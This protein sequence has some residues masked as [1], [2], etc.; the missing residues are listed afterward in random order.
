[1]MGLY[2]F[3]VSAKGEDRPISW[4]EIPTNQTVDET[5]NSTV[6][7]RLFQTPLHF[8]AN[9]GQLPEEA[10]YYAKSEGATVHCTD[11]GLVFGFAEGSISVKFSECET[12]SAKTLFSPKSEARRVKPEARGQLEGKVNYFI[13]NDPTSWRTDIPTF[14]EI[15]YPQ[16]YPGIDLIYSGDQRRLKYTFYL[17]PHSHPN[18]IQMIYEDIEGLWIDEATGE[19]V[20]QT[21]WGEM[22]DAKPVAYQE[23]EG[24]RNEVDIS[25][26]LMSEKIVGFALGDYNPNFMLILDPGYSTYLGGDSTDGASDITIDSSGN[27]YVV[28]WTG[29]SD[30]PTQ[31]PHQGSNARAGFDDVFVT[32]LSSSGNTLIYSTYLGG[33]YGE[34]GRGITVDNDGNVYVTG[35][36]SSFDFPTQNP[37]QSSKDGSADAFVTKLSSG[38][39]TL[40]YSTYLGGIHGDAGR[41]ITVD[42][43][44]SAYVTGNTSSSDFPTENPYQG[45][46]GGGNSDAFVTKLNSS[47]NTLTYSTYLGGSGDDIGNDIAVDS[48]ANAYVTGNTSS[49]DFPTQNPYQSSKDGSGDAFVT[50]LSSGGSTLIY[51]TYLGGSKYEQSFAI[52]VDG[53]GNAYVTGQ[54]NSSNFP[55]QNPYQDSLGSVYPDVFIT[56]LNSNGDTLIYSTYLGGSDNDEGSGIVVDNSR[57]AYVTGLT[58]SSNFP[59]QNPYQSSKAGYKDA[60]VTKLSNSGNTLIYST[61]LGGGSNDRGN[62]IAVDREDGVYVTGETNSPNFPT[63]NPYQSNYGGGSWDAFVTSLSNSSLGGSKTIYVSTTGND[64]NDGLSWENAKRTIQKGIDAASD[65]DTVLVADGIYYENVYISSKAITL[66]SQS[67]VTNTIIDGGQSVKNVVTFDYADNSSISGFS[68]INSGSSDPIFAYGIY[69]HSFNITI[70]SNEIKNNGWGIYGKIGTDIIIS[71]NVIVANS[72]DGIYFDWNSTDN[73]TIEGNY[74]S[75]NNRGGIY[76]VSGMIRNNVVLNNTSCG[77]QC[78]GSK[79]QPES[80]NIL[81]NLIIGH[82]YRG[83]YVGNGNYEVLN[84]TLSNNKTAIS[85][86]GTHYKTT[87]IVKNNIIV[88][89]SEKGIEMYLKGEMYTPETSVDYNDV[90]NNVGGNYSGL[91]PGEDDISA[92]PLFLNAENGDYH[93]TPGSPCI[94]VGDP[95]SDYSNEPGPNGGRINMG[96]YGN[97]S[98]AS[99]SQTTQTPV[100]IANTPDPTKN[101]TPTLNWQDVSGASAYHIQIDDNADFSSPIVDDNSLSESEYTPSSPLP[102]GKI[103][104]RVSSIR[105]GNESDFSNVDDFTIDNTAPSTP[106]VT[107]DGDFT[108][109]TTELHASW[110]SSDAQSD[111][112]EYQ[113]VIGTT[114]DGVDVV[115]CTSTG[116]NTDIT[117]TDLNL[118]VGQTY[119]FGVKSK[120]GVGLWSEVGVSDGITVQLSSVVASISVEANPESLTADGSSTSTIIATLKDES[121]NPVKNESV[122]MSVITGSGSVG[123]VANQGDGTYT[124]TYTAGTIEGQVTI[125]AVVSGRVLDEEYTKNGETQITLAPPSETSLTLEP[126]N[127]LVGTKVKVVGKGFE[128][129]ADIGKLMISGVEM[130]VVGV[131]ETAVVDGGIWTDEEGTFVVTF[132]VSR[133]PGGAVIVAVGEAKERFVISVQ[134]SVT[135]ERGPAGTWV[136]VEGEGFASEEPISVSFGDTKEIATGKTL[137]DGSFE[138][139]FET[140]AQGAGMKEILATGLL[141]ERRAKAD[142]ELIASEPATVGI[143]ANPTEIVADGVS[144]SELAITVKDANGYGVGGQN[145][146]ITPGSGKVSSAEYQGDG[147]YLATYTSDTKAGA[148]TIIASTENDKTGK[149]EITLTAGLPETII[150]EASPD[151][152]SA[153][154]SSQSIITATVKDTHGNPCTGD[155]VTVGLSGVGG[156]LSNEEGESGEKVRGEDKG[157]G[158]YTTT[159]TS[160]DEKGTVI[161]KVMT[162]NGRESQ[163]EIELSKEPNFVFVCEEPNQ[164]AQ[165]GKLLTYSIDGIGQND[166]D[167]PMKLSTGG[168]PEGVQSEFNPPVAEPTI[169]EPK[170][171]IRLTLSVPETIEQGKHDF[172]V[173]GMNLESGDVRHLKLSF[174]VQKVESDIFIIVTPKE[175]PLGESVKVSGKVLLQ[176]GEEQTN[177]DIELTYQWR[178]GL[179]SKPLPRAAPDTEPIKR[180]VRTEGDEREFFDEFVPD[181]LG[182][183]EVKASWEGDSK[184]QKS[185]IEAGYQVVKG[186]SSITLASSVPS[187]KLG[188]VVTIG[189]E[190]IP[191]LKG[192]QLSIRIEKPDGVAADIEGVKTEEPGSFQYDILLDQ[193]GEWAFKVVWEGNE[194][195]ESSSSEKLII[196]VVKEFGKVIIVLG[197]GNESTNQAWDTFNGVANCVYTSFKRRRFTDDDIYFLSPSLKP[198]ERVDVA[199]SELELERAITQWAGKS[200]NAY[201]PLYIYFL[202]HNLGENFL[203]E[204]KDDQH[205]F[206]SPQKLDEWLNTLKKGSQVLLIFEA[207]R[208]GKFIT[209]EA[210]GKPILPLWDEHQRRIIITSAHEDEQARLLRNLSSFSRYFFGRIERNANL[211]EAFVET[212]EQLKFIPHHSAQRPQIDANGDGIPNDHRDY[213]EVA[214]IYIPDYIESLPAI[215][216]ISRISPKQ[217]LKEG[218]TSANIFVKVLGAN[219]TEVYGT[220][221]P[222]DFDASKSI[223]SWDELDFDELEFF[224]ERDGKYTTTY[225]KF[226]QLGEYHII[227][228]AENPDGTSDPVQTIVTVCGAGEGG[229]WDVNG[230]GEVDIADLV[231]I[232]VNF[233]KSGTNIKGDVNSDGKVNINDLILV[234]K[235]FGEICENFTP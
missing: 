109:S 9:Q 186:V 36:T 228:Y 14:K 190:L 156:T 184:Y 30:F 3:P 198:D 64:D 141:S 158:T 106:V 225:D 117:A 193:K 103:Y 35:N 19:L 119:Y 83:I 38:G 107:D 148:V 4:N 139:I 220:V 85:I 131:G 23:M 188:D 209:A 91:S 194:S 7:A 70:D 226:T 20:I 101:T 164:Q 214:E 5:A 169:L 71:N 229:S 29:S 53:S 227:F 123:A 168:L 126:T 183:W 49:S 78:T 170:V 31:N 113:Y 114:P 221:I 216:E 79:E 178:G 17:Q 96:T 196:D 203:L 115:S 165:A 142:F 211:R 26:R 166:F 133:Q 87:A 50:K 74:I 18:Q 235:H 181:K 157:D 63:Q 95:T 84:N 132:L 192:E 200:V 129:N 159:Y 10:V 179:R 136:K 24:V 25:F 128:P 207:C 149:T 39:N 202:S 152:L 182:A 154:G 59:T 171:K 118:T 12:R 111:V 54:T 55:T 144:T 61:Y 81:N 223:G 2:F 151:T 163:T 208:S 150:V 219:I 191:R 75:N 6:L 28:G 138:V 195:Y 197:G 218:E 104:W 58:E 185:E 98:E 112:A 187:P 93:L 120:N 116:T 130:S 97:T 99:R 8:V 143:K 127:G 1:M 88:N 137:A 234:G 224:D 204:K 173:L 72:I 82:G 140:D 155:I 13:G 44:G 121:G 60:F 86:H 92:D 66:M 172:T 40:I 124:A 46:Y 232:G 161:I 210:D 77:I 67:G 135:P 32:K 174:T 215:P 15:I 73:I 102:E 108:T 222:P 176:E 76:G 56:K 22:R 42:N 180:I 147:V 212:V 231:L 45:S 37:H 41:S 89:S 47:G 34:V 146:T 52:A 213:V 69:I 43:D 68:I 48:S 177:L 125:T 57:S 199:T 16:V 206:L 201:V 122:T 134:I 80:T 233:G 162:Q 189:G 33:I 21:E 175:I 110:T 160:T 167:L 65:S 100:L 27:A 205:I 153:D 230:D 94:D 105:D 62:D 11:K 217:M 51:S 145:I 90:W